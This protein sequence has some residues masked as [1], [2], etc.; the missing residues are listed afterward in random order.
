M[1]HAHWQLATAEYAHCVGLEQVGSYHF[2]QLHKRMIWH[3]IFG[4]KLFFMNK[5]GGMCF[6]RDLYMMVLGFPLTNIK[7]NSA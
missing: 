7:K 1:T 3:S 4:S 6:P 5:D 2:E